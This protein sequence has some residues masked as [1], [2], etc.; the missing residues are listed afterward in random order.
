MKF[1]CPVCKKTFSQKP[2]LNK[3]ILTAH[4]QKCFK[5]NL[6]DD[7]FKHRKDLWIHK[8]RNHLGR[9]VHHEVKQEKPDEDLLEETVTPKAVYE[10]KMCGLSFASYKILQM[11]EIMVHQDQ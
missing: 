1:E 8:Q 11:H 4:G 6:C 7:E 10:C 5:C 9:K 3:H 2:N